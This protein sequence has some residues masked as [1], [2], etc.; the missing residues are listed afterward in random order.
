M[1]EGKRKSARGIVVRDGKMVSMYRDF[2]GRQYYT[3]PGGGMEEHETERECVK[4]EVF[5]EFGMVVEPIKKVYEYESEKSI[6]YFYVC[7]WVSGE[8]GSG[9]GEEYQG[10]RNRGVYRPS[11]IALKDLP[12]LPLMPVEIAEAL[13]SDYMKN[14]ETVR[15]DVKRI[16]GTFRK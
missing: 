1:S 13:Y 5:E 9:E 3:I 4:R 10:D 12:N 16:K 6:E 8:F 14:G 2:L 7:N 11:W 15:D